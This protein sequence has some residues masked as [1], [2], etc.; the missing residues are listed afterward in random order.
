MKSEYQ[1]QTLSIKLTRVIYQEQMQ[2]FKNFADILGSSGNCVAAKLSCV[3]LSFLENSMK[4]KCNDII[5]LLCI[6]R[7]IESLQSLQ[8]ILLSGIEWA[9]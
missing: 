3:L 1:Y 8:M 9:K 7:K 5:P 2:I 6:L 4:V